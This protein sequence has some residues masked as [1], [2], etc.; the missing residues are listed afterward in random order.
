MSVLVANASPGCW[1]PLGGLVLFNTDSDVWAGEHRWWRQQMHSEY[2]GTRTAFHLLGLTSHILTECWETVYWVFLNF[3]F[4]WEIQ[5]KW[6][7][8]ASMRHRSNVAVASSECFCILTVM[9]GRI[10][11]PLY[12]FSLQYFPVVLDLVFIY[13]FLTISYTIFNKYFDSLPR[14]CVRCCDRYTEEGNPYSRFV[15]SKIETE[16]IVTLLYRGLT[17]QEVCLRVQIKPLSVTRPGMQRGRNRRDCRWSKW[18]D[19]LP[20][21]VWFY[22]RTISLG[23][24]KLGYL[25][26]K[27]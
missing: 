2:C 23:P 1:F 7:A 25:S 24:I 16:L 27:N 20:E 4:F 12:S 19:L 15:K 9:C 17:T 3:V 21:T 13:I 11:S 10:L 6:R 8:S 5:W 26:W 22:I 14:L 18:H